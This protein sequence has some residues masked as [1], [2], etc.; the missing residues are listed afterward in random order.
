MSSLTD[1]A[2]Q[3]D[4][5][6]NDILHK[7]KVDKRVSLLPDPGAILSRLKYISHSVSKTWI[8]ILPVV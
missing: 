6:N 5:S 7:I 4:H 1:R 3:T 2:N 8:P